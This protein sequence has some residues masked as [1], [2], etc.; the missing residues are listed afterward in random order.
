M[1]LANQEP[2]WS[3]MLKRH[4]IPALFATI[5]LLAILGLIPSDI[6]TTRQLTEQH[7]DAC[8]Q[9]PRREFGKRVE[10][11]DVYELIKRH[12]GLRLKPYRDTEGHLTIGYGRALNIVGISSGE[13]EAMLHHDVADVVG[14]LGRFPWFKPLGEVRGAV[15][16]DMTF[17]LGWLKLL[18]FA[19]FLDA[20]ERGDFEVAAAEMLNS[21]W[22][23]QVGA[24][25]V[26]LSTMMKTGQWAQ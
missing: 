5:L 19:H 4:G 2:W 15:L 20:I 25:A 9:A 17:N 8:A 3:E 10:R 22:A 7:I 16:I 24:R 26:E 13:A 12:E 11:M 18:G 21:E 6:R 23:R 1:E 14:K